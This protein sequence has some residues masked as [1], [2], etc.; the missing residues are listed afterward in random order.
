MFLPTLLKGLPVVLLLQN[1]Y[2]LQKGHLVIALFNKLYNISI[3]F[4]FWTTFTGKMKN[5]AIRN[6]IVQLPPVRQLN[7]ECQEINA[8]TGLIHCELKPVFCTTALLC[9]NIVGLLQQ[10]KEK[11]TAVVKKTTISDTVQYVFMF[12]L[13]P[14]FY[15]TKRFFVFTIQFL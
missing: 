8:C 3:T 5:H 15:V 14:L 9:F 12:Y 10:K 2:A 1:Q 11:K 6:N 4:Q 7:F 13:L